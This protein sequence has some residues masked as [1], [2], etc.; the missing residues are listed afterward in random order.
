KEAQR[1]P[2]DFD[3]I[4][5][6][7][8]ASNWTGRAAQSIW[9]AQ[10]VHR[11]EASYIPPAKYPLVHRAVLAACD[12]LD[13]VV[14]G[15]LENPRLCKFDPEAL[16][17]KGADGPECLTAPQV[18]AA[19]KI[20]GPSVQP[21]TGRPLYPG[22]ER[23]SEMGWATW[24][25]PKPLGIGLDYFRFVVFE[26]PDWDFRTLDFDRDVARAEKL[27]SKRINATDPDL[28]PFF[29]R[30]GK[31][32]QYHGWSDPQISPGN[33]VDYYG[34]VLNRLGG[35]AKVQGSYRLFMVPGMGHCGG[36]DG[37]SSFDMVGALERWV[38]EKRPPDR[39]VALRMRD[40][41]VDRTRPL[42]PYPQVAVYQGQ[43]ST[44][45][46]AGFV[47]REAR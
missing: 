21:K 24:A 22:L 12:S 40:G 13:G 15:V 7:A 14:D 11:D 25:G 3:G 47:C 41:K 43:G 31:L 38:E 9:T 42:C 33:S 26:N 37:T 8:P 23:G 16:E 28:K 34:S 6:G 4:V 35:A 2:D 27:D 36:G 20:Y 44:D 17:C 46:E 29:A 30:G 32:I 5:A 1:F 18:E 10:A 45:D 39:I 19:R